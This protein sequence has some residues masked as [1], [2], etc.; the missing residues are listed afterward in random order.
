MPIRANGLAIFFRRV[1]YVM[2]TKK[3]NQCHIEKCNSEF[4]YDSQNTDRKKG[5]WRPCNRK[6]DKVRGRTKRGSVTQSYCDQRRHSI[7]RKHPPPTYSLDELLEWAFSQPIFHK[8]F[9]KWAES[10][11]DKYAKPSFDR[12]DD[13]QGYSLD[14]IQIITW[15]ENKLKW[16]QDS[17]NGI[18]NKNSKSIYQYTKQG[19]LVRAF[20]SSA[21]AFR[22]TGISQGNISSC[23]TGARKSCGGF[24]WRHTNPNDYICKDI[25]S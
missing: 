11:Y 14:N 24:V 10:G 2:G 25:V 1:I 20:Y 23:C 3:C 12:L 15:K 22:V 5:H 17:I 21:E 16:H 4:A 18:N 19:V 7:T 13:Y 9:D 6:R 8:L